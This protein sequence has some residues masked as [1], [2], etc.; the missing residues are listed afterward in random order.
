MTEGDAGS[1][2]DVI[3]SL[4]R[5]AGLSVA[6]TSELQPGAVEAVAS[7][8][9]PVRCWPCRLLSDDPSVA[10]PYD[11]PGCSASPLEG[12]SRRTNVD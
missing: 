11:R 7:F 5:L 10:A 1:R 2:I 8:V 12:D 4:G 9:R 6:A 3:P